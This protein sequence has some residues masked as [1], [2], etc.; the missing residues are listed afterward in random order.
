M[1][2]PNS[3]SGTL[4]VS[5]NGFNVTIPV[6]SVKGAFHARNPLTGTFET[7][8][9]S[10]YGF[11]DPGHL[12]DPKNG[13]SSLLLRCQQA[14]QTGDD[15]YSGELLHEV[16]CSLSGHDVQAL[17]SDAAPDQAV[18]ATVGV[19]ADTGQ[20]RRVVLTGPFYSSS[21][22]STFTLV[23]TNYGENVSITPPP[24]GS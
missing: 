24:A 4:N 11:A 8:D 16:S 3:F 21:K 10:L 9:P 13:L 19:A 18:A 15:R 23:V 17:L 5:V 12:M 7:D 6:V 22:S 14:S 20:L 2:R 1:K